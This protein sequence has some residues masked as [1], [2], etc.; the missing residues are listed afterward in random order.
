MYRLK[1][2]YRTLRFCSSGIFYTITTDESQYPTSI[3]T[4]YER[5]WF[6]DYAKQLCLHNDN[7]KFIFTY[8][9]SDNAFK[10]IG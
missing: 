8:L 2:N 10:M 5:A 6:K 9:H 4:Y 3:V 1:I 7:C